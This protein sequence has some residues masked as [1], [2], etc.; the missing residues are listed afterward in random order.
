MLRLKVCSPATRFSTWPCNLEKKTSRDPSWLAQ[1][2]NARR[3][4]GLGR[5]VGLHQ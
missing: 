4:I 3:V 1:Q 2:A 5:K